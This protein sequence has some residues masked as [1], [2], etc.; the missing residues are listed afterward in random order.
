MIAIRSRSV[1]PILIATLLAAGGASLSSTAVAAP[2]TTAASVVT[3]GDSDNL[4]TVKRLNPNKP[5]PV[6]KLVRRVETNAAL[7]DRPYIGN[8]DGTSTWGWDYRTP[9]AELDCLR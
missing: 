9:C 1:A 5:R 8:V 4:R 6:K 3:D 7:P 2:T